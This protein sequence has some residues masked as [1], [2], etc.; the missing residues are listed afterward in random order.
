MSKVKLSRIV[1]VVREKTKYNHWKNSESVIDWFVD[2]E[3]KQKKSFIQFD[4]VD[5]YPSISKEL[6]EKSL[7]FA[8]EFINISDDDKEIFMQCRNSILF[9]DGKP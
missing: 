9:N 7:T 6:L 8:N 4:I 1:N 2:I 5:F 3:E